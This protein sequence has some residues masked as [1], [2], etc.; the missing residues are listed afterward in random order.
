MA[1]RKSAHV[2]APSSE[3]RPRPRIPLYILSEG[4]DQKSV[5][6][7]VSDKER[8]VMKPI[9]EEAKKGDTAALKSLENW[10]SE[11]LAK[12]IPETLKTPQLSDAAR[13]AVAR[14]IAASGNT[15]PAADLVTLLNY[16]LSAYASYEDFESDPDAAE[17]LK[18]GIGPAMRLAFQQRKPL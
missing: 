13:E 9:I 14:K 5:L 17:M 11:R 2:P 16:A 8:A 7:M 3:D 15:L 1:E 18:D 12:P 6:M 10:Y 4:E